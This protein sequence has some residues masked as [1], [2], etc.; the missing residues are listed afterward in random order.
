MNYSWYY[1]FRSLV[2]IIQMEKI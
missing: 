2:N 1:S